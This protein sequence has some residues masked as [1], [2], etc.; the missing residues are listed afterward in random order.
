M[1]LA[2]VQVRENLDLEPKSEGWPPMDRSEHF[3]A[4]Q[5]R[6]KQH[7]TEYE[8][9]LTCFVAENAQTHVPLAS[10]TPQKDRTYP[11]PGRS[12][13]VPPPS[14]LFP[15]I[16]DLCDLLVAQGFQYRGSS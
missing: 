9:F 1:W 5:N 12:Q 8:Q 10:R 13:P 14:E 3:K 11:T 16:G 6:R 4:I 2:T 15:R 7:Q